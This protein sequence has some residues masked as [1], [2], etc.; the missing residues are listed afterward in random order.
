MTACFDTTDK[1]LKLYG[2]QGVVDTEKKQH[3]K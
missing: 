2:F 3:I 1:N